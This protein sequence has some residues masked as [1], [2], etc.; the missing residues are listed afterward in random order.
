MDNCP[1]DFNSEVRGISFPPTAM[2]CWL[3]LLSVYL[4]VNGRGMRS[5]HFI[6]SLT[7]L[8]SCRKWDYFSCAQLRLPALGAGQV[9]PLGQPR[10]CS[11]RSH[12]QVSPGAPASGGPRAAAVTA[13]TSERPRPG[14]EPARHTGCAP[15]SGPGVTWMMVVARRV[16]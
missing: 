16:N 6:Y 15:N 1:I 2:K 14:P 10:G 9:G 5:Q 13:A 4:S 7:H 12:R 8:F 3:L 11:S